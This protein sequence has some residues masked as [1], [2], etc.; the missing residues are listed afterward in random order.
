M[1]TV[2]AHHVHVLGFVHHVHMLGFVYHVHMLGFVHVLD[3]VHMLGYALA[4]SRHPLLYYF[5]FLGCLCHF[6]V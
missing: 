1:C 3:F 6:H 4:M 5:T 2:H